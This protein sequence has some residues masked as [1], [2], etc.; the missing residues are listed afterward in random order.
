MAVTV[1]AKLKVKAGNESSFQS[2]AEK[3]IAHVRANEPGTLTYVL[4]RSQAVPGEFLFYEVYA[5]ASA[6]A[7]HGSSEPMQ[8]FFG[9]VG[10]ILDGR[11]EI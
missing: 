1:V 9:A 11:P 2:E 4:N 7:A 8:K 5:D 6:L 10:G 3:M